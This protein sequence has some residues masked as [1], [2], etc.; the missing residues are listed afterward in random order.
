MKG[1]WIRQTKK[2]KKERI[3][4]SEFELANGWKKEWNWSEQ[5]EAMKFDEA[6][7]KQ[8][9]EWMIWNPNGLNN[10]KIRNENG[11]QCG[12]NQFHSSHSIQTNEFRIDYR[13]SIWMNLVW[14]LEMK[15]LPQCFYLFTMFYR[16]MLGD[17]GFEPMNTVIIIFFLNFELYF[18]H[19]HKINLFTKLILWNQRY[20]RIS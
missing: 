11:K 7:N 8:S 20:L 13:K 12:I 5:T 10:S 15:W 4:N 14:W 18:N 2:I 6:G 3:A 19:E 1:E 9:Q 16:V 17:K